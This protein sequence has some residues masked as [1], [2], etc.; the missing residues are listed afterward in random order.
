MLVRDKRQRARNLG[1][2]DGDTSSLNF[3]PQDLHKLKYP[4]LQGQARRHLL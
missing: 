2:V 1:G 3:G 4:L